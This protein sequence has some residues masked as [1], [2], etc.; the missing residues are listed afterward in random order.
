M[1]AGGVRVGHEDRGQAVGGDL[2]DRSAG[3]RDDQVGRRERLRELGQAEILAQV[4]AVRRGARRELGVVA[5][6]ADVQHPEGPP[7]SAS[8]GRQVD[9][10]RPQR[11][12]EDEHAALPG[13][14]TEALPA[15][16]R[17][18]AGADHRAAR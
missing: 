15:A 4:V 2:E 16:S 18:R 9:R 17:R 5:A 6:P 3:A 7:A 1:I 13:R 11:A 14:Q 8:D 12:A 10:A